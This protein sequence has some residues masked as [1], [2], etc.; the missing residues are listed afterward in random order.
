MLVCKLTNPSRIPCP[1]YLFTA[2]SAALITLACSRAPWDVRNHG[3]SPRAETM[4]YREMAQDMLDA[5]DAHHIERVAVIGHSMGGKIA[6]AMSAL[7]PQRL[8]RLVMF[9][10]APS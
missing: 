7:A 1:F 3:L 6:M 8:E 5:L 4:S 9:D 10:I 2:C